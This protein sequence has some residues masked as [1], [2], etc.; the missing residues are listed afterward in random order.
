LETQC[1]SPPSTNADER[2]DDHTHS[3]HFTELATIEMYSKWSEKPR[4]LYVRCLLLQECT[5]NLP[6][7][8]KLND[9]ETEEVANMLEMHAARY[10]VG[11]SLLLIQQRH[12]LM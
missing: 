1:R 12:G 11:H 10:F 5:E 4:S 7:R 3:V 6:K 2:P 9:E 8:R